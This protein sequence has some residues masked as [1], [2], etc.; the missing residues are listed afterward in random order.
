MLAM[1]GASEDS[2]NNAG[3]SPQPL[4]LDFSGDEPED[5]YIIAPIATRDEVL[6]FSADT[7]GL[8]SIATTA[9]VVN[10]LVDGEWLG[11]RVNAKRFTV[12]DEENTRRLRTWIRALSV[13]AQD[14]GSDKSAVDILGAGLR[15]YSRPHGSVGDDGP[16]DAWLAQ[17]LEEWKPDVLAIDTLLAATATSDTNSNDEAAKIMRK[18]RWFAQTYHC[19]LIL[20]HH[21]RKTS[22]ESPSSTSQASLRARAWVGQTDA[23]I[24]LQVESDY[25]EWPLDCCVNEDE[26]TDVLTRRSFKFRAAEKNRDGGDNKPQRVVVTSQKTENEK[27]RW[28]AVE[29]RGPMQTAEKTLAVGAAERI[30]AVVR[31]GTTKTGEIAKALGWSTKDSEWI[32]GLPKAI[33]RGLIQKAGHGQ[34]AYIGPDEADR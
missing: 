16:T 26:A 25:E 11:Y 6:L 15:Y 21:E 8:K 20:L 32:H 9:L 4:V 22:Q 27:Y 18:L 10:G 29:N 28:M 33:E 17:H 2:I 1:N 3:F 23:H 30:A 7:G 5:D 14:F 13:G 24:T 34:Y 31:S 19:L 12:I